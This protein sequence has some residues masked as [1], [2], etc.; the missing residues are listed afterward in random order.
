MAASVILSPAP[1]LQFFDNNGVPLNGGLI[2]AFAA[3]TT[4]PQ[5]VYT[6]STGL[7]VN[8]NPVV[9][10]AS[11][12]PQDATG[13]QCGLWL[14]VNKVYKL[15][16]CDRNNVQLYSM[17]GIGTI[18]NRTLRNGQ[19]VLINPP[20]S[21][22]QNAAQT[23]SVP[24]GFAA[25]NNVLRITYGARVLHDLGTLGTAPNFVLFITG[26]SPIFV[27]PVGSGGVLDSVGDM[28]VSTVYVVIQSTSSVLIYTSSVGI[29][30]GL[31]VAG[32]TVVSTGTADLTQA[33]TLRNGCP[34]GNNTGEVS[35]DY[36]MCEAI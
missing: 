2:Y 34:G 10:N 28:I 9:L 20:A 24:A 4:T 19:S 21:L 17:D 15:V 31:A 3:G 36:L 35:F 14:N 29:S 7:V 16:V 26:I 11:G 5:A 23:I 27:A 33:W 13:S 1:S 32:G 18:N 22:G 8:T 12:F 25:V 6:D 30:Q